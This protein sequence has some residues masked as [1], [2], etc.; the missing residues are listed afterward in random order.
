MMMAQQVVQQMK[1]CLDSVFPQLAALF[2]V[3][4][5]IQFQVQSQSKEG[6]EGYFL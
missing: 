1:E 6:L 3:P 2:H 4:L 5:A